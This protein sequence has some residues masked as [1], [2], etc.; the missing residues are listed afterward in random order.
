MPK[1]VDH[2]ERRN[3]IAEATW[4]VILNQGMKGATVRNI[5]REAGLS[6][7]ALRHYFST[8]DELLVFAMKLVK[9]RATERIQ[10]IAMSDL[11]PKDKIL[12]IMLELV[13]LDENKMAEMEVWFAFTFYTRHKN[14]VLDAQHDGIY[15]GMKKLI[16]YMDHHHMLRNNL[17]KEI[18]TEKL[19]ALIDGIA[20]HA[21]LEPH[22]VN[23]ER[24]KAVLTQHLDSICAE[25]S[26][27]VPD[28]ARDT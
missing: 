1:L 28:Q 15:A 25:G 8:Q 11:P 17:D 5:A 27:T 6:L 2:E 10:Q 12:N 16:D 7:G 23:K 9:D 13:P 3:H 4:R 22:R 14:D 20:I 18:E 26:I 19:Y 21:L 24:I